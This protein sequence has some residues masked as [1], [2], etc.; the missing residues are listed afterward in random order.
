[1]SGG[2]HSLHG[3]VKADGPV[4]KSPTSCC[5]H[6]WLEHGVVLS[7]FACRF[8]RNKVRIGHGG[9]GER[10]RKLKQLAA[11]QCSEDLRQCG[12]EVRLNCRVRVNQ[13][14]DQKKAFP[15]IVV[16]ER[17]RIISKIHGISHE[18][19]FIDAGT[20]ATQGNA[21]CPPPVKLRRTYRA[22]IKQSLHRGRVEA[23]GL[24]R[25]DRAQM[26]RL[27]E[28]SWRNSTV[29]QLTVP[30]TYES[31]K[32]LMPTWGSA[33]LIDQVF[34]VFLRQSKQFGDGG[35]SPP[36][37]LVGPTGQ[38]TRRSN[39]TKQGHRR[40]EAVLGRSAQHEFRETFTISWRHRNRERRRLENIG[41]Y[42]AP[43]SA[44]R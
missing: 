38:R 44:F 40:V 23:E 10:H 35:F 8:A 11:I 5:L 24:E 4:E 36:Q 14:R 39:Q 12:L 22:A 6:A 37:P 21:S 25:P 9:A 1:M 16:N 29:K 18:T 34:Q 2:L 28:R 42:F 19:H 27:P 41:R 26:R 13:L 20:I 32:E 7:R 30:G 15:I 33:W 17:L 31:T 43:A 3:N